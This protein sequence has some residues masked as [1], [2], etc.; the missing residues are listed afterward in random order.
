[1]WHKALFPSRVGPIMKMVEFP[2]PCKKPNSGGNSDRRL[3]TKFE[4]T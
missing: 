3:L 4:V 2:D 1:M